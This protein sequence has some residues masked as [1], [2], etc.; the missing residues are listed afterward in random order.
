MNHFP[1]YRNQRDRLRK[2][3]THCL[4]LNDC[5]VKLPV[6]RGES[7]YWVLDPN[8]EVL[9]MRGLYTKRITSGKRHPYLPMPCRDNGRRLLSHGMQ[10]CHERLADGHG[11]GGDVL[12]GLLSP[13]HTERESQ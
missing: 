1:Y 4:S 13:A 2:S 11:G 3:I 6:K 5:F 10:A 9:F 7:H 12:H 8:Q